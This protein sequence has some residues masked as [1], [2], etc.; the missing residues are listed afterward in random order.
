M[1]T[2]LM[3]SLFIECHRC[4]LQAEANMLNLI[5][6]GWW[7]PYYIRQPNGVWLQTQLCPACAPRWSLRRYMRS[8][9]NA[10]P[11]L[12]HQFYAWVFGYFWLPCPRCG[13]PFGGHEPSGGRVATSPGM[14]KMT[15]RNCIGE[16]SAEESHENG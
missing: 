8:W 7:S 10:A 6:A 5:L 11:R 12:F 13:R 4:H 9:K 16:W 2:G 15:C 1:P 3:V 14:G